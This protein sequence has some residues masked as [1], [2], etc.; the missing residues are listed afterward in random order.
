MKVKSTLILLTLL[1]LALN[2]IKVRSGPRLFIERFQIVEFLGPW[3]LHVKDIVVFRGLMADF[4]RFYTGDKPEEYISKLEENITKEYNLAPCKIIVKDIGEQL[5]VM[6]ESAKVSLAGT[7]NVSKGSPYIILAEFYLESTLT[8]SNYTCIQYIEGEGILTLIDSE[9]DIINRT[10]IFPEGME[11]FMAYPGADLIY[12]IGDRRVSIYIFRDLKTPK[13][14]PYQISIC[15]KPPG[16]YEKIENKLTSA[17]KELN[18]MFF[19]PI[20]S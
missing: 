7:G 2:P 14:K 13:A 18:K 6:K 9:A 1:I 16:K 17:E 20:T 11:I 8:S 10:F 3:K 12:S 5:L 4:M 15:K 19:S